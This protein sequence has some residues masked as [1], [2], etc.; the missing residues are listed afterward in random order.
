MVKYFSDIVVIRIIATILFLHF[1]VS[2]EKSDAGNLHIN[3]PVNERKY[4][5]TSCSC[6][7]SNGQS[8]NKTLLFSGKSPSKNSVLL[9]TNSLTHSFYFSFPPGLAIPGCAHSAD[10]LKQTGFNPI[11][12]PPPNQE[13]G[14]PYRQPF[15]SK[16]I[17]HSF[18]E[19]GKQFHENLIAGPRGFLEEEHTSSH[20]HSA[21]YYPN[22]ISANKSH[23]VTGDP[24]QMLKTINQDQP[25]LECPENISTYTDINE[26]SS[27]VSGGLNPGFDKTAV[28]NLTWQ[29]E[30]AMEDA[31]PAEG[32]HLI[33]EYTFDEG[34]TIITYTATTAN[35]PATTCTFTVTI[36][37]NQVPRL[38]N[39]PADITVEAAPGN[40]SATVYWMEPAATDNCTPGRLISKE[41]TAQPGD[42][43]PVGTTRVEYIAYDA[44]GNTSQPASFTITVED[45]MPPAFSL[46][47]DTTIQC[48][49]EIPAPWQTLQQLIAA[50]GSATDNC[51]VDETTF[52]LLSETQSR[53][54]CP[55]ILTRVYE[56][57]DAAGNVAT[58]E[59]RIVVEGEGETAL[60][61]TE[62]EVQLKSGMATIVSTG[63]GGAWNDPATWVGGTIPDSDD[64]VTISTGAT[65][66]VDNVTID[67]S[68]TVVDGASLEV[69]GNWTNNGTFSAA[70]NSNVIFSGTSSP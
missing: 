22:G 1:V 59:H 13:T 51:E 19:S 60:A 7:V 64:N 54:T 45:A 21:D 41:A 49:D 26:C 58:A 65:V 11:N 44:M 42:E 39:I 53:E 4:F 15:K 23:G 27:F 30:G 37:D 55:Y 32:I 63:T 38:E 68:L 70:T 10:L 50:G 3:H 18:A 34:T 8:F 31:S 20:L 67:G 56:I 61:E 16:A 12:A 47:P 46:P 69:T 52:H 24:V 48:G 40:C 9:Q 17:F 25:I 6:L 66:T 14:K 35:G 2:D 5:K 57:A 33:D 43:F 62:E 28:V 36:S 29:M